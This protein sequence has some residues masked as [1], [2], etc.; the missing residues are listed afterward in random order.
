MREFKNYAFHVAELGI[1]L[2]LAYTLFVRKWIR[3]RKLRW[4]KIERAKSTMLVTK[5][6]FFK[7]CT[8]LSRTMH[9]RRRT[10]MGNMVRG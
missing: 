4:R 10:W 2:K 3:N 7:I 1:R 6:L 5:V 9:V 8:V